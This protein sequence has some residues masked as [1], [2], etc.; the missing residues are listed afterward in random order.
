MKRRGEF[1]V[2]ASKFAVRQRRI[3]LRALVIMP[4]HWHVLVALHEPWILLSYVVAKTGAVL[5][6]QQTS[7]Q[8]S[9]YDTQVKTAK[10]LESVNRSN[11]ILVARGLVESMARKQCEKTQIGRASCRREV[12]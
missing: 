5:R 8:N 9:Y 3:Y 7:W 12:E 2:S 4:N 1:I 6:T 11:R 10:Q